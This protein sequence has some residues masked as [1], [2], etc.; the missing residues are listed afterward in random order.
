MGKEDGHVDMGRGHAARAHGL[1]GSVSAK[2][3]ALM[4]YRFPRYRAIS[5]LMTDFEVCPRL[6]TAISISL[7]LPLLSRQL[8]NMLNSR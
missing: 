7:S 2:D 1:K 4:I 3:D 5:D 8:A 6:A